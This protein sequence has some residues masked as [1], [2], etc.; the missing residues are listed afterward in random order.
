MELDI[1]FLEMLTGGQIM[2]PDEFKKRLAVNK[3]KYRKRRWWKYPSASRRFKLL[4]KLGRWPFNIY[5]TFHC[6]FVS[7]DWH[8]VLIV[9]RKPL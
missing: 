9:A 4:K 2:K 5:F 8:E 3:R 1:I 6:L 7:R